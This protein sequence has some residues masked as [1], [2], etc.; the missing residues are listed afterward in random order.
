MALPLATSTELANEGIVSVEDLAEVDGDIIKQIAT[1]MRRPGGNIPCP[2]IG[3]A[4]GAP[5]GTT[6][7]TPP[8]VFGSKSQT[9]LEVAGN[10]AR[11]YTEIDRPLTPANMKWT[12]VMS[13]F[14]HL[15]KAIQDRKKSDE[16]ST[17]VISKSLPIIRWTEAFRDHLHRCI[18]VRSIPLAYV[19]R[20]DEVVVAICPPLT[21]D[22]PY[23]EEWGSVEDD[24]INR[25]SHDHGLFRDDNASV[26]YK[27]EESTRGTVYADSIK[28][29][30]RRKDGRGSF[31]AL[32]SQYAGADKWEAE[33]KRQYLLLVT[34][35]W[36]GQ[37][38]FT[39]ER[40]VQ[41]HRNA[42][43]SM[44]A[45]AEHIEYQLPIEHT[46]VTYLLDAIEC[47]DAP[48]QAA[49]ALVEQD[50]GP[51]GARNSFEKAAAT[52]LPKDPV[53]KR[54]LTAAKRPA[55][56]ISATVASAGAAGKAGIGQS[57]VHF[58][59]HEPAEY[60]TLSTAQRK[61]LSEWRVANGTTKSTKPKR[62]RGLRGGARSK[63]SIASA[64][65]SRVQKKMAEASDK[66]AADD[67]ALMKMMNSP[68]QRAYIM[69]LFKDNP[70]HPEHN[71]STAGSI[72]STRAIKATTVDD[73]A[74]QPH[75]SLA[76]I[77]KKAAGSGSGKSE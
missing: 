53:V 27:L 77:L 63:G 21:P 8:F 1:N 37:A 55:G 10:L 57:G 25:A 60:D 26:Y 44:Q 36:R 28:P 6:V 22:Q 4:N 39:L 32:A 58:R 35:K 64:V 61:E 11:F 13:R 76:S 74:T 66:G 20:K 71:P 62:T 38:A 68:A 56:D 3:R 17:P 73:G 12:H 65:N 75:V 47:S 67:K 70:L 7:P 19:I 48:L 54:R 34:S 30:Q 52:I 18:G 16:P 45:C 72:G 9:R 24:L 50:S 23:S 49:M 29:F 51:Q 33:I 31:L 59:Y 5:A 15:W 46:R 40:F 41:R 2:T 69:S 14:K 42:F 43:V